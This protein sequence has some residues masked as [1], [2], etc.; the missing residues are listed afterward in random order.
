[1]TQRVRLCGDVWRDIAG[2]NDL[3]AAKRIHADRIDILVDLSLHT[4]GNRLGVFAKRPAPIQ[5]TYLAYCGT[6][7]L[8]AMDYRISDIYIDPMS[9][10]LGC[11]S[12]K[13]VRLANSYW[14]YGGFIDTP[15]ISPLPAL[16]SDRVTFGCLNQLPKISHRCLDVWLDILRSIPSAH[17]LLL[18]PEGEA[19]VAISAYCAQR[20]IDASRLE[21]TVRQGINDYYKTYSRIDIA[22][23]PFPFGG[24]ITTCD[25]LWMGV[26]VVTLYGR[27]AVGRGGGSI[28][29]HMGLNGLIAEN[30]A[31]YIRIVVGLAEDLPRLNYLRW[32][33]RRRMERSPLRDIEGHA[34]D[35]E[36]AFRR[37]WYDWCASRK[38]KR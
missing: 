2:L 36:G 33:L 1:M 3:E 25:A 12:E 21:F 38:Y 27:T 11:Y 34:R 22:L 5:I 10:D 29:S 30:S 28:L 19:R 37:I 17:L 8:R 18:S 13:T 32:T 35:V 15:D 14:C 6:S 31:E 16:A 7:G 20:G 23:D 9:A 26:P 4:G 24:G